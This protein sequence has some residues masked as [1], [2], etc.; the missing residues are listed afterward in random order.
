MAKKMDNLLLSRDD[1][2][3]CVIDMQEK[4]LPVIHNKDKIINNTVRLIRF[5]KIIGL[6]ILLTEQEKLGATVP[7]IMAEIPNPDPMK[8]F[9]FSAVRCSGFIERVKQLHRKS[10]IL[11]GIETHICI[12]QTAL[13][14]LPH[15][16]VHVISDAVS[17]RSPDDWN[18]GLQRMRRSGVVI[19]STEMV[20]FELLEKAGTDEF[21]AV[22]PLVK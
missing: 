4:L 9:E 21:K 15:Y 2:A 10:L 11:T 22:L 8:K 16:T 12:A 20:I 3:L 13:Q 7:E 6:P 14:L 1:A 19:S 17:S 18:I 5:A